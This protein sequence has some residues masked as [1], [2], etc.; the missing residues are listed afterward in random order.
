MTNGVRGGGELFDQFD[1]FFSEDEVVDDF[2]DEEPRIEGTGFGLGVVVL[3]EGR[4]EKNEFKEIH[5]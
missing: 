5:K 2:H 3:K 1:L 4:D